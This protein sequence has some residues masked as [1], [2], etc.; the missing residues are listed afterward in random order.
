MHSETTH[1]LLLPRCFVRT[2]HRQGAHASAYDLQQN[3]VLHVS[4]QV[5]ARKAYTDALA[6]ASRKRLWC[7]TGML[8]RSSLSL[9]SQRDRQ[10]TGASAAAASACFCIILEMHV[11]PAAT[12]ALCRDHRC[13]VLQSQTARGTLCVAV[14]SVGCL[15]SLL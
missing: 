3:H 15:A 1:L 5:T 13:G 2:C 12:A 11:N 14:F 10:D 6:D 7:K 8:T 4:L 9:D